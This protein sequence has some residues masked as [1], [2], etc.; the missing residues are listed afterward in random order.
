MM[1]GLA[2]ILHEQTVPQ[3]HIIPQAEKATQNRRSG[4]GRSCGPASGIQLDT[5]PSQET[6]IAPLAGLATRFWLVD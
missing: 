1:A 3:E 2:P 5:G 4:D 6:A